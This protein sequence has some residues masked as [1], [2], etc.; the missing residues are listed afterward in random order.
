VLLIGRRPRSQ[1]NID[2]DLHRSKLGSK[3]GTYEDAPAPTGKLQ[4]R[5]ERAAAIAAHAACRRSRSAEE[6]T[7]PK[8]ISGTSDHLN[9]TPMVAINAVDGQHPKY[10]VQKP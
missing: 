7:V 10:I 4:T 2:K 3:L 5:S 8:V 6:K 1:L 9:S